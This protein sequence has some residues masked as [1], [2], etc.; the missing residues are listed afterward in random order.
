MLVA[1][2]DTNAPR[3]EA[4]PITPLSSNNKKRHKDRRV[5]L[6]QP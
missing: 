6:V 4:I 5:M 2:V 1:G 3:T